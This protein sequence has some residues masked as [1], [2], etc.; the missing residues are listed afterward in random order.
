MKSLIAIAALFLVSTVFAEGGSVEKPYT[1][2]KQ[3]AEL[4][5]ANL[6]GV[7][8]G[9]SFFGIFMIYTLI[10]ICIEEQFRNRVY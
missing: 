8:V 3:P 10:R 9:F 5:G 7:I 6:I 2:T 4:E 1:I